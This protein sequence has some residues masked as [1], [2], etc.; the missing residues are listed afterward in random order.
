M[1]SDFTIDIG[2]M[3]DPPGNHFCEMFPFPISN[4][5]GYTL[6]FRYIPRLNGT[7]GFAAKRELKLIGNSV[8][9]VLS[10]MAFSSMEKLVQMFP[11]VIQHFDAELDDTMDGTPMQC[12]QMIVELPHT[13]PVSLI[14]EAL[15]FPN[16]MRKMVVYPPAI[17]VPP[18]PVKNYNQ[19]QYFQP[20]TNVTTT[21]VSPG[22]TPAHQGGGLVQKLAITYLLLSL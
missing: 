4:G 5:A 22:V 2:S 20:V 11:A 3:I 18:R 19:P 21:T 13:V 8:K 6:Y 10:L 14:I 7:V 12:S 17:V 16:T 1:L 9:P 15:N